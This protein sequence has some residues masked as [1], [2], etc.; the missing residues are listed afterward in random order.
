MV[1]GKSGFLH[2][3]QNLGKV[4]SPER[5]GFQSKHAYEGSVLTLLVRSRIAEIT[6]KIQSQTCLT[7][8][9]G[10]KR[11]LAS[12]RRTANFPPIITPSTF[13]ESKKSRST[14]Q[15]MTNTSY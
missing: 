15:R 6:S 14:F 5:K 11:R 8:D 10:N 9:S 13:T 7:P 4:K 3:Y 12:S 1:F 2:C